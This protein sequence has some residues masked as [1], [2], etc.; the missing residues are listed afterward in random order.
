MEAKYRRFPP[1]W[2]LKPGKKIE[3]RK[4]LGAFEMVATET[5]GFCEKCKTKG[6]GF[7]F[8]TLDSRGDQLGKSGAYWCSKCGEGMDPKAYENFVKT[9]LITPEM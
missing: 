9:E 3:Y 6:L 2:E 5:E 7:S 1:G 8:M 4:K